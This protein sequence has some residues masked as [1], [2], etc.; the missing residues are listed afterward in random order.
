MKPLD[1]QSRNPSGDLIYLVLNLDVA[2]C[3]RPSDHS[4]S[5]TQLCQPLTGCKADVI[6][7]DRLDATNYRQVVSL[8]SFL[9]ALESILI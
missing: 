2:E 3:E 4:I 5:T 7:K 9:P 6:Y 1:R 8:L